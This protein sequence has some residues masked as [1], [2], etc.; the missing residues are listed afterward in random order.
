MASSSRM[1]DGARPKLLCN[2]ASSGKAD[3]EGARRTEAGGAG[4]AGLFSG[5]ASCH[6]SGF[7]WSSNGGGGDVTFPEDDGV[8]DQGCAG[9]IDGID[10]VAGVELGP[11]A[12]TAGGEREYPKPSRGASLP[13]VIGKAA[14]DWPEL[15]D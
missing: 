8:D 13:W 6:N 12:S 1:S 11:M 14:G 10:G 9:G 15:F 3:D 5:G 4:R 7:N 2:G